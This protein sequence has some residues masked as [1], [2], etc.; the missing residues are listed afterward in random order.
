MSYSDVV[1]LQR[2][3][4]ATLVHFILAYVISLD[5]T[6][7]MNNTNTSKANE[8]HYEWLQYGYNSYNSY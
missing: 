1:L 7:E 4:E 3:F 2:F 6:N 8:E 5:S